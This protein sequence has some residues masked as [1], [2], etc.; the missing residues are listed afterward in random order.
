MRDLVLSLAPILIVSALVCG[1]VA[2][3][4]ARLRGRSAP[5]WLAFGAVLGPVALAILAVAPPAEC[6]R[7]SA[8]IDGWRIECAECGLGIEPDEFDDTAVAEARPAVQSEDEVNRHRRNPARPFEPSRGAE[9][10]AFLRSGVRADAGASPRG[11]PALDADGRSARSSG[12]QPAIVQPIRVPSGSPVSERAAAFAAAPAATSVRIERSSPRDEEGPGAGATRDDD[13]TVEQPAARRSMLERVGATRATPRSLESSPSTANAAAPAETVHQ[14]GAPTPPASRPAAART[15]RRAAA[16]YQVHERQ[17]V[18]A[19]AIFVLGT[20]PLSSGSRYEL[21]RVGDRLV[22]R[23]PVDETPDLVRVER[24]V[25][26][27]TAT[28][29]GDDLLISTRRDDPA[30]LVLTFRGTR[31]RTPAELEAAIETGPIEEAQ[32]VDDDGFLGDERE[33]E[34]TW[35][36]APSA[37]RHETFGIAVGPGRVERYEDAAEDVP[38]GDDTDEGHDVARSP[39]RVRRRDDVAAIADAR[40]ESGEADPRADD[41]GDGSSVVPLLPARGGARRRSPSSGARARRRDAA[42]G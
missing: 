18:L 4:L 11:L 2:A 24:R 15:S 26:D 32:D 35:V 37:T 36:D 27:L 42:S 6:P 34:D 31:G 29:L 23:G 33:D 38:V 10:V 8:P 40:D 16:P 30:P 7:C 12:R 20:V 41:D 9:P 14:A 19:S 5:W 22:V 28:V 21:A 1:P 25:S 3:W 13:A 39:R 17:E